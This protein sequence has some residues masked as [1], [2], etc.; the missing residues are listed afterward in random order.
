MADETINQGQDIIIAGSEHLKDSDFIDLK[1]SVGS[2]IAK[3]G[4][5]VTSTAE[6]ENECDIL[7]S[8]EI[9]KG[10]IVAPIIRPS[11]SYIPSDALT[12]GQWVKVLKPTGGRAMIRGLLSGDDAP[13]SVKADTRISAVNTGLTIGNASVGALFVGGTGAA[14]DG[15]I[16]MAQD[17]T[18][19]DSGSAAMGKF[20]KIWF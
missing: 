19:G 18:N 17:F 16:R 15:N 8:G 12:D 10:V 11:D 20:A 9:L 7:A 4:M 14:I 1:L 13:T 2:D 6:S 5:F 3:V